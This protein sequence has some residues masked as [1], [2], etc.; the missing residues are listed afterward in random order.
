MARGREEE[1][2]DSEPGGC[3]GVAGAAGRPGRPREMRGMGDGS[4][5]SELV[6]QGLG[7]QM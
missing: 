1:R 4:E 5:L 2:R 6:L 7:R 3:P